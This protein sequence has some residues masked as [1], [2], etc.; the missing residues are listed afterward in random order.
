MLVHMNATLNRSAVELLPWDQAYQIAQKE[1]NTVLFST[2]LVPEREA[3]FEWVGPIGSIKPV[4]FALKEKQVNVSSPDDLKELKIGVVRD[5]AD[6]PLAIK[7]GVKPAN[8]VYKNKT[9]ELME[10]LKAEAI[11][12]WAYPNITGML[13][14]GQAGFQPGELEIAYQLDK[15]TPLYFAFNKNISNFTVKIFRMP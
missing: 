5:T 14:A 3:L 15:E 4:L 7:A 10:L 11:D 12:V 8:L 6:G 1:N 13:L 9:D 2:G